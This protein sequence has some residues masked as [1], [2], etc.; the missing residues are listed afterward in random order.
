MQLVFSTEI[1]VVE[2]ILVLEYA[3]LWGKEG[4]LMKSLLARVQDFSA[5][6]KL[7]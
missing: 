2:T 3:S 5:F 4:N 6:C 7:S 1:Y